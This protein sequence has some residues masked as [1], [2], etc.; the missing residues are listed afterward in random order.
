MLVGGGVGIMA[1]VAAA[2]AA[3]WWLDRLPSGALLAE[4]AAEAQAVPLAAELLAAAVTAGLPLTTSASL[5]GEAVGGTLGARLVRW[6]RWSDLGLLPEEAARAL[7]E[8]AATARLGRAVAWSV[9]R[10]GSPVTALESLAHDERDRAR[11][12]AVGRAAGLGARAALPVGLCLLPAFLALT[13]APVVATVGS[14][15]LAPVL[16]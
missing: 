12:A 11:T 4:E 6:A 9:S 13:V 2:G 3:W 16:P 10:G 15:V 8:P 5:V 1:G 7:A 14:E